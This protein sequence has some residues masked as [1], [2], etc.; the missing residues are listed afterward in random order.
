[1]VMELFNMEL[2]ALNE[3]N[4]SDE[5]INDQLKNKTVITQY[6]QD[7]YRFFKLYPQKTEHNDIF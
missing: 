6:M 4:K 5:L 1:M 7:L 3:L 2:K